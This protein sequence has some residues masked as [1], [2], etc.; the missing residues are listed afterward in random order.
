[1]RNIQGITDL[2][3]AAGF[4]VFGE[5]VF[6]RKPGGVEQIAQDVLVLIAVEAALGGAAFARGAL[7]VSG[8]ERGR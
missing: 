5:R 1:M 3:E 2:V 7:G 6:Y 4:A 8:G